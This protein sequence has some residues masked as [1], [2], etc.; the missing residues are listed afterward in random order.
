MVSNSPEIS[1]DNFLALISSK[2]EDLI[3]MG[4]KK[5]IEKNS[6]R[7]NHPLK[8]VYDNLDE[9]FTEIANQRSF[10]GQN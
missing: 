6:E 4:T 10:Y 8:A 2:N 1:S 5:F 3:L 9:N 7:R